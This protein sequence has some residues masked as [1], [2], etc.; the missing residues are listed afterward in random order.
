MYSTGHPIL[1]S[2]LQISY[3]LLMY[4][5]VKLHGY[6]TYSI[7]K[8]INFR[9]SPFLSIL[10]VLRVAD[11]TFIGRSKT[12]LVKKNFTDETSLITAVKVWF[13]IF[14]GS[15]R[16]VIYDWFLCIHFAV[17]LVQPKHYALNLN[18]SS[19]HTHL[20]TSVLFPHHSVFSHTSLS[21]PFLF[22]LQNCGPFSLYSLRLLTHA[23]HCS[24][25]AFALCPSSTAHTVL[26]PL[27]S[28]QYPRFSF[29]IAPPLL[30]P[31]N[32]GPLCTYFTSPY[33][34][35]PYRNMADISTNYN[36]PTTNPRHSPIFSSPVF[37]QSTTPS[38]NPIHTHS[39]NPAIPIRYLAVP[40]SPHQSPPCFWTPTPHPPAQF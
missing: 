8:P 3:N 36:I 5:K 18:R 20:Q 33:L 32:R 13:Y 37:P 40:Y 35:S 15:L 4:L 27:P 23:L 38:R 7:I 21:T 30:L 28:L 29:S 16:T 24:A 2:M 10:L 11:C 17:S 22:S 39:S 14:G 6:S 34:T 25:T 26:L 31:Y 9:F 19:D 1:F 12:C